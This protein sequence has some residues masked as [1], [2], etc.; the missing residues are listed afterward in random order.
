VKLAQCDA[1]IEDCYTIKNYQPGYRTRLGFGVPPEVCE[2]LDQ[3]LSDR[4]YEHQIRLQWTGHMEVR[5]ILVKAHIEQEN[6]SA[7]C[8]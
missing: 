1:D 6:P 3:K 8:D 4:G 2:P 5:K 7:S